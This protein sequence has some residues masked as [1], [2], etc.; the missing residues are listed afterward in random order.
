MPDSK[1]FEVNV[2]NFGKGVRNKF[3]T[4]DFEQILV[5]TSGKGVIATEAEEK[6][7]VVG[8]IVIIPAGEKHWHGATRDSE[9]SHLYVTR[10]GSKMTQLEK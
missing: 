2:V 6:L 7:V 9:F 8:D 10:L 1:E 3:H 4:H 5:V